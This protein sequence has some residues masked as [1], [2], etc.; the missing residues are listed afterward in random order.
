MGGGGAAYSG[1]ASNGNGGVNLIF[2]NSCTDINEFF[3][4]TCLYE[5]S[6]VSEGTSLS[7]I[8]A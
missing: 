2:P 1:E 7:S 4:N 3:C 8:S 5:N 6:E